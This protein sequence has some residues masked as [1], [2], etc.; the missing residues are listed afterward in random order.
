MQYAQ[1]KRLETLAGGVSASNTDFIKAAHTVL[2]AQG[3][4]RQCRHNRHP[5]IRE[6]LL[7]LATSRKGWT[8]WDNRR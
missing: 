5:W 6:G 7:L 1:Y 8:N 3:K 4:T 2:S